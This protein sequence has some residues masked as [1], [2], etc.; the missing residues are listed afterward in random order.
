[1]IV[2]LGSRTSARQP[3]RLRRRQC[4]P[5]S[6]KSSPSSI[7]RIR[8]GDLPTHATNSE[9]I[10]TPIQE[11]CHAPQQVQIVAGWQIDFWNLDEQEASWMTVSSYR[12]GY[13]Y[14]GSSPRMTG[15]DCGRTL[16]VRISG[17]RSVLCDR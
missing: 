16:P 3:Q 17:A 7:L 9:N 1:M 13:L 15:T 10:Q 2:Q 14:M 4:V 12:E 11:D 8:R 6:V 5:R